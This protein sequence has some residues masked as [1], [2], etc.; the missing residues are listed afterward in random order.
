MLGRGVVGASRCF[1]TL[2]LHGHARELGKRVPGPFEKTSNTRTLLNELL[3]S[4][5]KL[6]MSRM[7]VKVTNI[8]YD[9]SAARACMQAP[10]SLP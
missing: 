1:A 9:A 8:N 5:I 7:F 4:E 10:R 6:V 3:R 2:G